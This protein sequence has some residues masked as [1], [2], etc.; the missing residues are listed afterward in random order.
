M[1]P[2]DEGS[3]DPTPFAKGLDLDVDL[4][5]DPRG[6]V[7][8]YIDD[9]ITIVPDL[10]V[11]QLRGTNAIDL[12]IHTMFRHIAPDEPIK[13]DD[14]LSLSK[15]ALEGSLAE[16]ATI[17]G[18]SV[19]SRTLLISL[20][21]DKFETWSY[22]ID[23]ILSQK[24]ASK[25][26]LETLV[27]RLNHAA[28]VLPIAQYFLNRIRQ[29]ILQPSTPHNQKR[30]FSW[31]PKPALNDLMLFRDVFLPKI[32]QGINMNLLTY[33]RPT[34]ILFSDAC[35]KGLGGFSV[36]SGSAWRWKIPVKFTESVSSKNNLL[37]FLAAVI[38]RWVKVM[39][40]IQPALQRK[41]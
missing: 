30:T 23:S 38:T 13:R 37:E 5:P 10:G 40:P 26:D 22:D 21:T 16:S 36:N 3:D 27:G 24:K 4:Y 19:N 18:W 12:A 41:I 7:D 8:I 35:P 31:L 33:R 11:S 17:L 14:C 29:L 20:P 28:S 2:L 25:E 15:L 1:L 39:L 6:K 34:H 9:G 32:Y